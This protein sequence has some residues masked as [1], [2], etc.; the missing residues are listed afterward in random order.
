MDERRR[1][2]R[3][4]YSFTPRC[5]RVEPSGALGRPFAAT[6]VDLSSTGM[7]LLSREHLSVSDLVYLEFELAGRELALDARVVRKQ[8]TADG[9]R[10][11]LAFV[12]VAPDEQ[13][14]ITKFVFAQTRSRLEH[15]A[16]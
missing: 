13:A 15:P 8:S 1:A 3:L 9:R 4:P 7:A 2:L 16:A 10:Y 12:T 11:G 6:A 5:Y 14:L